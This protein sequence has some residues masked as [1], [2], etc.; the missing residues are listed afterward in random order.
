MFEFQVTGQSCSFCSTSN[1]LNS[2][3]PLQISGKYPMWFLS[4]APLPLPSGLN[5][6]VPHNSCVEASSPMR[7]NSIRDLC[8]RIKSRGW[9]P[10]RTGL[11]SLQ[12]ET[13]GA[14]FRPLCSPPRG[15]HGEDGHQQAR[16]RACR[17]LDTSMPNTCVRDK[18]EMYLWFNYPVWCICHSS[19]S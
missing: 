15:P 18:R 12:Q 13:G 16:H 9:S 6:C 5:V 4:P 2:L 8:D 10:P 3:Q 7:H 19:L 14:C 17:H 1:R 11:V